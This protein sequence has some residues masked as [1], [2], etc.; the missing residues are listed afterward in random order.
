VVS[1]DGSEIAGIDK[2]N[3]RTEITIREISEEGRKSG[4]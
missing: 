2:K 1:L 4:L 3:P